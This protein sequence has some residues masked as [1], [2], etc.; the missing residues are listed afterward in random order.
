MLP[1]VAEVPLQ[2]AD[3]EQPVNQP[4]PQPYHSVTKGFDGD[5]KVLHLL[6]L[7]R[8]LRYHD[9][10]IATLLFYLSQNKVHTP[11]GL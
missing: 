5:P 7:N 2:P 3:P 11:H 9:Q 8:A 6:E 10:K 4:V 1:Q